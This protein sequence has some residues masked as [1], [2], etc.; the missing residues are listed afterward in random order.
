MKQHR[1]LAKRYLN[2]ASLTNFWDIVREAK[3]ATEDMDI[4]RAKFVEGHSIVQIAIDKGYSVDKVQ[5]TIQK[6][7]DKV[8]R[9]L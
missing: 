8:A 4:L 1:T 7:Y 6:C 2:E 3:I 9:L 5:S